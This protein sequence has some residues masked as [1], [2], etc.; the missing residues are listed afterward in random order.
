[1]WA[2]ALRNSLLRLLNKEHNK[3][4]AYKVTYDLKQKIL[5]AIAVRI[6]SAPT[7]ATM[8]MSVFADYQSLARG[9]SDVGRRFG[10]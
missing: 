3:P 1:M 4:Y 2:I 6:L 10:R 9:T 5:T 7:W 8:I